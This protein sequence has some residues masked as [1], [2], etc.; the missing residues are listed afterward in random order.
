[1]TTTVRPEFSPSPSRA[2][3][4]GDGKEGTRY[5]AVPFVAWGY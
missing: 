2:R 4:T 5:L 1:V 3:S